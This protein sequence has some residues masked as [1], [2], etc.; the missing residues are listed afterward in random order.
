M[1]TFSIFESFFLISIATTFALILMLM[2]YYRARL[3]DIE[4]KCD[5][6]FELV[7]T[8]ARDIQQTHSSAPKPVIG[9]DMFP[10]SMSMSCP[11]RNDFVEQCSLD[12]QSLSEC[13]DISKTTEILSDDDNTDNDDNTENALCEDLVE[14]QIESIDNKSFEKITVPSIVKLPEQDYK[15]MSVSQIRDFIASKNIETPEPLQKMKKG[16]LVKLLENL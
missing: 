9:P 4:N 5:Q 6:L 12:L 7:E 10:F 16:D 15:K 2:Y 14:N 13:D 8:L 11:A 1:N 3:S